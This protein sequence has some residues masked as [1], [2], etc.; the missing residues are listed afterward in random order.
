MGEQCVDRSP[1]GYEFRIF[2]PAQPHNVKPGSLVFVNLRSD[3]SSGLARVK[4]AQQ[5]VG[6]V[7]EVH[8][9]R[10]HLQQQAPEHASQQF[11]AK[12]K[13]DGTGERM[14]CRCVK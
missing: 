8:N 4:K 14:L 7:T 6:E 3:K 1:L 11:T 10:P 13:V 12:Y 2:P 9:L 5:P